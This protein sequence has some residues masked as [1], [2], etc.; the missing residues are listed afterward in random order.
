MRLCKICTLP[1]KMRAKIDAALVDCTTYGR[2]VTRFSKPDRPINAMNLSRHRRHLLPKE[3]VRRAPAPSPEVATTLLQR[4]ETLVGES[5]AIAE[6]AKTGQQWIAATSAL[7]EVRCCIELL[8]K[9][10]GEISPGS[11]NFNNFNFNNL[12]EEHLGLFLDSV[13][14]RGDARI[15][16]LVA[17]KLGF[18]APVVEINFVKVKE[19]C[20][21]CGDIFEGDAR[22]QQPP[23]LE[24]P[25]NGNG[26][27]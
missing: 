10:S 9:L 7:R 1:A 24:A 26:H 20:P 23:L 22:P 8:G 21:R 15:Q 27:A 13:A 16:K 11:I 6:A 5:R 4:V 25:A 12:T 17:E 19:R 18:P 2:I 3:L 14:K